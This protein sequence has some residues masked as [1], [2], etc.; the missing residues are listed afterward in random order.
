MLDEDLLYCTICFIFGFI[1]AIIYYFFGMM[2]GFMIGLFIISLFVLV[3]FIGVMKN[4][5]K[6]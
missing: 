1:V 4:Y 5:G 3:W 6:Q 2:N